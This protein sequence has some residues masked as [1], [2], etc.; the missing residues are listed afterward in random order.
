MS[1][2]VYD[3]TG[4]LSFI[5]KVVS[6]A[7]KM[8]GGGFVIGADDVVLPFNLPRA[9]FHAFDSPA[10]TGTP[11]EYDQDRPL[12]TNG[13]VTR[14][15]ELGTFAMETMDD[16]QLVHPVT[17]PIKATANGIP[18]TM[19]E[20]AEDAARKQDP[21][22]VLGDDDFGPSTPSSS[23]PVVSKEKRT[24]ASSKVT[25]SVKKRGRADSR[26][27]SHDDRPS[28]SKRGRGVETLDSG[29]S[30]GR[31]LRPRAAKGA[32]KIREQEEM[33]RAFREAAEE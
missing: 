21:D 1:F 8:E 25:T 10:S 2:S 29:L 18:K 28:P 24:R 32:D 20:I 17:I 5:I 19:R 15:P 31:V 4:S 14:L 9:Q 27:A 12:I 30:S 22:E 7:P 11:A 3:N 33:E 13:A 26:V 16:D 23:T 6:E